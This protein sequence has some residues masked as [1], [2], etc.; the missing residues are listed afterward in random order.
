MLRIFKNV[1]DALFTVE[2]IMGKY[3]V[4]DC[5]GPSKDI[6]NKAINEVFTKDGIEIEAVFISHF[7]KDHINGIHYLLKNFKVRRLFIPELARCQKLA[8]IFTQ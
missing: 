1:G 4:Y 3:F 6:I 5:G 8:L 2:E 7:D